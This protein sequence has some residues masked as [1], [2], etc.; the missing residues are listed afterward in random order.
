MMY[1][2]RYI[3]W[4]LVVGCGGGQA[5]APPVA[6]PTQSGPR[7]PTASQVAL[8]KFTKGTEQL[9]AMHKEGKV[10][11]ASVKPLF[12]A[13]ASEDPNFAEAHYN[14]GV[15]AESEGKPDE[16]AS[17]YQRALKANPKMPRAIEN[18]AAVWVS[19][20]KSDAAAGALE[21][22]IKIEPNEPRPRAAL[23]QIYRDK[24][25]TDDALDQCRAALQRDPQNLA[26]FETM[27]ATYADIGNAPMSRLVAARGLKV[28]GKD[29]ALHHVLARHLLNEN[30]IPE[31]VL[32]LKRS[33]DSNPRYRPARIDIAEV[34]LTYRDFGNAKTHYSELLNET[35]ND[36]PSLLGLGIASKGMGQPDDAKAAYEKVLSLQPK[37]PAATLNLA[38]LQ[39]RTLN[40]FSGALKSYR[41]YQDNP[42]QD[43]PKADEIKANITELEATIDAL[44]Q[45]EEFEKQAK[46]QAATQESA[47]APAS[48]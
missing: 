19:Q 9:Q 6:G 16:A 38:I 14:L 7:P 30:K 17:H 10:D 29:A 32:E 13:A 31:A 45:A 27:A 41:A 43:G 11:Y 22:F 5:S 12:K 39:H 46:D 47:P 21:D 1:K 4:V 20:G 25:R 3:A 34:A 36:I 48:N 23:A 35:P 37:H 40:D 42:A 33:L 18:L 15:I 44:K 28:D 8:E 24:K 26:A 2:F